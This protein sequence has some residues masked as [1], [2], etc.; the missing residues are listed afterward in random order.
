MHWRRLKEK[1]HQLDSHAADQ[2]Q[3]IRPENCIFQNHEFLLLK[4]NS[5]AEHFLPFTRKPKSLTLLCGHVIFSQNLSI[6]QKFIHFSEIFHFF[7]IFQFF[8]I[9]QS[10]IW[11]SEFQQGGIFKKRNN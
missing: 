6:F 9:F 7:G 1:T 5:I 2:S 10:F 4:K 11:V 8:R 3:K